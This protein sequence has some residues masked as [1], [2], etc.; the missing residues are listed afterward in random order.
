MLIATP[1]RLLP[2][3]YNVVALTIPAVATPDILIPELLIVTP[4]PNVGV[5]VLFRLPL[6]V[7]AVV[8]P[9]ALMCV[10]LRLVT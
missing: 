5:P 9:D 8:T 2:S 6:K 1:V 4:N 7:V 10:G 3:P